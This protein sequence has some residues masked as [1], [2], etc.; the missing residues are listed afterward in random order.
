M[1][2]DEDDALDGLLPARI[3]AQPA[4]SI[5]PVAPSDPARLGY[6]PTF[7]IE[8]ALQTAST[9]EICEEYG[10]SEAEWDLIRCEELFIADLKRAMDMLKQ[11]GMSFKLKARLQAEALLQTSWRLIHDP[12]AP[13]NVRAQLIQA[14]ARWAGYDSAAAVTG[15]AGGGFSIAI[16]FAGER[17]QRVVSDQ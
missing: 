13:A 7:P 9:Q 14:T 3:L 6:P 17:P 1:W 10:I 4:R 8:I 12:E 16:N 2:G 11:E 5:T 15:P